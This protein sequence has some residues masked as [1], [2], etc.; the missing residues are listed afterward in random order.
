[1]HA[2]AAALGI[3]ERIGTSLLDTM[4]VYLQQRELLLLL[5]NFEHLIPAAPVVAQLLAAAPHLRVLV[6]SREVLRLRGE[7]TFRVPPL[8]SP[9]T[10]SGLNGGF[11]ADPIGVEE[12]LQYPAI[13]LFVGRATIAR[14]DFALSVHNA[15]AVVDICARLEGL[16]LAI[17]LAAARMRLFTPRDLVERLSSRLNMLVGGSR[18]LPARQ[19]TLRATIAWSYD[20]LD[21]SEQM[22]FRRLAVFVGGCSLRA[23][24]VVCYLSEEGDHTPAFTAQIESLIDKNLLWRREDARGEVRIGMLETI[25]E[26]ASEQLH[27]SKESPEI[28][29]LHVEYFLELVETAEP[30][31]H[32]PNQVAY[33]AEL[34]IEYDN[35]RAALRYALDNDSSALALR[36]VGALRWFWTQ[37]SYISE[38]HEWAMAALTKSDISSDAPA[39]AKALWCAGVLAWL[40]GEAVAATLLS[41]SAALWR[42]LGDKLGL[43]YSLQHLGLVALRQGDH[44]NVLSL[45]ME[46]LALFHAEDN[47]FGESLALLCMAQAA[48]ESGDPENEGRWLGECV[49]IARETG[50]K[51]VLALALRNLGRKAISRGEF[52]PARPILE[53]SIRLFSEMGTK[54]EL[55]ATLD[56]AATVESKLG[57]NA[58]AAWLWQQAVACWRDLGVPRETASDLLNLGRTA[59]LQEDYGASRLWLGE[60][61]AMLRPAHDLEPICALLRE[62]GALAFA[63]GQTK[64]AEVLYRASEDLQAQAIGADATLASGAPPSASSSEER[65]RP[66]SHA[67]GGFTSIEQ[68]IEYAFKES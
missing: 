52:A 36:L 56:D 50:D 15:A 12:L 4:L 2:I 46:S 34:D 61:L 10:Y 17:E 7:Y 39:R 21:A 31:L 53:E 25:R 33:L 51:W 5:D 19:R 11:P 63:E 30:E 45:E 64:R 28:H 16:P 42:T 37:R 54:H 27:E 38:G 48:S 65:L 22:L 58:R 57:D 13:D 29:R 3:Q 55:A 47:R 60:S 6:T 20:L 35:V 1:M 32:G 49:Q 67:N 43:A 40:R 68:A 66:R 44:E 18:D 41:D 23:A 24:E 9:T 62:F 8:S 14:A 59:R 26:Y